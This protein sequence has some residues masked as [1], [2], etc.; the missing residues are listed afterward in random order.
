LGLQCWFRTAGVSRLMSVE[1]RRCH[2]AVIIMVHLKRAFGLGTS[3]VTL[4]TVAACGSPSQQQDQTGTMPGTAASPITTPLVRV[5]APTPTYTPHFDD[6]EGD[7][8]YYATAASDE[9]QK[10][11]QALGSVVNFRYLGERDGKH[12]IVSVDDNGRVMLRYECSKPCKIIKRTIRGETDRIP[13]DPR[14]VIGAA[15]EDA[16][17]GSLR[18]APDASRQRPVQPPD[19]PIPAA[20]LG[21]WNVDLQ[22]CGSGNND[23]RLRI[24][25]RRVHFYESVGN[26]QGVTVVND[27]SIKVSASFSGE[28][29]TWTDEVAFVLSRS[30]NDL[31]SGDIT[32]HRCPA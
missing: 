8:Y 29:Q 19:A 6:R 13:Y 32:R 3:I 11:G 23:S 20:F 18:V 7:T 4:L 12:T 31:N 28:G 30:G 17:N 14:S 9:D 25:P 26:V 21:E 15:F 1:H 24:E 10:K 5:P 27:R 2:R 22:A 16:L